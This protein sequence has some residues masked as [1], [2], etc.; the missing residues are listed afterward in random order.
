MRNK[1][2]IFLSFLGIVALCVTI[3]L[4]ICWYQ[5][6]P[7]EREILA[8]QIINS[9]MIEKGWDYQ[10]NSREYK[11]FMRGIVWGAYPELTGKNSVFVDSQ[12]ELDAVY[13]YAWKYSGYEKLYGGYGEPNIDEARPLPTDEPVE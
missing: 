7:T 5:N 9:F 1:K 8:E 4:T 3:F 6:R 2:K 13:D 10:Q 12:Y 11:I